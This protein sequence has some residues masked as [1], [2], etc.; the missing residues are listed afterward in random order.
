MPAGIALRGQRAACAVLVICLL[1]C[2]G[3]GALQPQAPIAEAN[4]VAAAL[5]GITEACAE[6]QQ[7][8]ALPRLGAS[9]NGPRRA[10]LMR[11]QELAHV[12]VQSPQWI[13]QGQTLEAVAA[14]AVSYLRECGLGG[15]AAYLGRLSAA[16]RKRG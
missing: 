5:T 1:A 4:R 6:H 15:V 13:Y 12:V 8:L 3:C 7:Q 9:T 14:S 16:E 11:S 10:A 2:G